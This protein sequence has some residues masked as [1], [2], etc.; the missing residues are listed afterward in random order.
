VPRERTDRV[1]PDL[2]CEPP[3]Q[4]VR[5][6]EQVDLSEAVITGDFSGCEQIEPIFRQCHFEHCE[7]VG[8]VLRYARF[9]DCVLTDSDLS[10]AVL[11]ECS[12]SR[13]E[14]RNCRASGLQAPLGRFKDVGVLA[15]KVD[16]ANFR[17]SSWERAE[18]SGSDLTDG[19]FYGAKMPGS[20]ILRCDLRRAELS[21]AD[22][23]GSRLSGSN[24]DGVRG[25]TGLRRI[26]ISSDQIIPL[27]L[28][29]FSGQRIEVR[30]DEGDG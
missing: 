10:G 26:E 21:R 29:L 15:S 17:M 4:I 30:D 16:G 1:P 24:L 12:L 14:F 13:V 5:L 19:D 25:A 20:R 9:V 7:F 22:L 28:A 27:A 18:M 8:S 3:S 11:E 23:A 2:G 6:R